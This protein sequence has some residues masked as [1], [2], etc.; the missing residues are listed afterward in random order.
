MDTKPADQLKKRYERLA[1]RLARLEVRPET[2]NQ[3]YDAS[4]KRQ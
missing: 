3:G 4:R 2:Q 1:A